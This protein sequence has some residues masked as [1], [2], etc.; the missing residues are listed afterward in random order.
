MVADGERVL[1]KSEV[2]FWNLRLGLQS[3]NGL[4]NHLCSVEF[5]GS[6]LNR[7]WEWSV[8]ISRCRLRERCVDY[9]GSFICATGFC[10]QECGSQGLRRQGALR[11]CAWQHRQGSSQ[12]QE[13]RDGQL[14]SGHLNS[15][16]SLQWAE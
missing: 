3:D 2:A 11:F 6:E 1:L 14:S 16:L 7:G 15:L 12:V 10:C 8:S 13:R 9:L 5:F 4:A